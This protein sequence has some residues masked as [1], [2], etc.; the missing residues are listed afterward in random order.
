M[1]SVITLRLRAECGSLRP[2]DQAAQEPRQGC[3]GRRGAP[4]CE[5]RYILFQDADLEYSPSHYAALL[6][7]VQNFGAQIVMGK[8]LSGIMIYARAVLLVSGR[9]QRDHQD[10]QCAVQ[11]NIHGY[12]YM[13][14][15]LP[16]RFAKSRRA[17]HHG[18]RQQAE[19]R[20][21]VRSKVIY[22]IP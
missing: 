17:G 20:R 22:E 6:F 5:R 13:L 9:Q 7:P 10:I 16:P 1:I 18:V 14:P 8:P 19:I 15:T 11:H 4:G 21:I 12:L 2:A 3:G